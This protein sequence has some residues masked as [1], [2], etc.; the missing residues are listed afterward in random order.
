[1]GLY[2]KAQEIGSIIVPIAGIC[3]EWRAIVRK[4]H[5]GVKS[6]SEK[7]TPEAIRAKKDAF[8]AWLQTDRH[9]ICNFG[10]L[11]QEKRQLQQ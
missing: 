4:E 1:M 11:R 9:L 8:K 6:D 3:L 7:R 5:L 2:V 10:T